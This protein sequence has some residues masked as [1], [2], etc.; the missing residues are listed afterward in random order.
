MVKIGK[1]LHIISKV[2]NIKFRSYSE[3]NSTIL[4][5]PAKTKLKEIRLDSLRGYK[6]DNIIIIVWNRLEKDLKS[7]I[8]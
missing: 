7:I 8:M 2:N 5:I 3:T 1:K 6:I 4:R